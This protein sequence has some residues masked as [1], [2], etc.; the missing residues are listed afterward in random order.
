VRKNLEVRLRTKQQ[1]T[2]V[3]PLV[4]VDESVALAPARL[5]SSSRCRSQRL[6]VVGATP[7]ATTRERA[8]SRPVERSHDEHEQSRCVPRA[9]QLCVHSN[10]LCAV[11]LGF[12]RVAQ[13]LAILVVAASLLRIKAALAVP[14]WARALV[15]LVCAVYGPALKSRLSRVGK[16]HSLLRGWPYRGMFNCLAKVAVLEALLWKLNKASPEHG[17]SPEHQK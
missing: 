3:L 7:R 1:W 10:S 15:C 6:R 16:R 12:R 11:A 2:R 9:Y 13:V 8:R 4:F 14:L 17:G 5:Q